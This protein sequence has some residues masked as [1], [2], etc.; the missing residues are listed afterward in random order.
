MATTHTYRCQRTSAKK[1]LKKTFD[2][3]N[4]KVSWPKHKCV[5]SFPYHE[6]RKITNPHVIKARGDAYCEYEGDIDSG[7]KG[8]TFS[9]QIFAETQDG[10]FNV[11]VPGR[12]WFRGINTGLNHAWHT[13]E[14]MQP[15]FDGANL[16]KVVNS[17]LGNHRVEVEEQDSNELL[18]FENGI[19][20]DG[21]FPKKKRADGVIETRFEGKISWQ[22]P[23]QYQQQ[24]CN[25]VHGLLGND[26]SM[27]DSRSFDLVLETVDDCSIPN[28]QGEEGELMKKKTLRLD[29]HYDAFRVPSLDRQIPT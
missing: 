2:Q 28:L 5:I 22:A 6:I 8:Y 16:E 24:S 25:V 26:L 29:Y 12:K 21:K 7:R 17:A 19:T 15:A 3:A 11:D 18:Q 13:H 27:H 10:R 4:V 20:L 23:G 9:G 1:L 14:I